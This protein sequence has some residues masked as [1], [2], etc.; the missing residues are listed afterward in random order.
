MSVQLETV[1]LKPARQAS[2]RNQE[3]LG[4]S[5]VYLALIVLGLVFVFPLLWMILTSLKTNDQIYGRV[6]LPHPFV[7]QN[8]PEAVK[9]IHF[10][11]YAANTV[12]ICVV[13][14]LATVC[15][16]TLVAYGFARIKWPGRNILFVVMLSTLMLPFQATMVPLYIL[17]RNLN[18]IGNPGLACYAPILIPPFFGSAFFIFLLR[19]FLL[20]IPDDLSDAARCDGAGEL[21]I[22]LRVILPLS[23]PAI[24]T[25]ALLTF[26][27]T[28]N[29]FMWPLIV[30]N[31]EARYTLCL[32]LQQYS[33]AHGYAWGYLCAA[34]TIIVAPVVLLFLLTQ[35]T[36]IEGI[37]LTGIK[38]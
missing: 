17:F 30:I 15:S 10:A 32:G 5:L 18:L 21:A 19:Q 16:C 29:D 1:R 36:F 25:V 11:L 26:M 8:F 23:R 20:G 31:D 3:R 2:R 27:W 33:T 38:G 4:K 35:R 24:T 34:S 14:V 22:L 7:W 9:Y 28:W 13:D 6:W 37:A 12:F